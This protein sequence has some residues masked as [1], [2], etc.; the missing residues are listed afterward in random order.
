MRLAFVAPVYPYRGGI[1]QFAAHL[2]QEAA[3][4]HDVRVINF[5]RLYP[6]F[7]FPGKTQYDYSASPHSF[8]SDRII[9]SINPLSWLQAEQDL[10]RWSP[11]AVVFHYWHPF[12]APAYRAIA[13]G[14]SRDVR[15]IGI[16]HNVVSHDSGSLATRIARRFFRQLDGFVLHA[17][18]ERKSLSDL[19]GERRTAVAFHPIYNQFPGADKNKSK[20]R[21]ELGIQEDARVVLYFG[22][23]RPYKGVDLLLDAVKQ[24]ADVPNLLALVVGEIYSEREKITVAVREC[25][26]RA[27]LI[28]LYVPNEEVAPYFRAADLVVLPYRS[29]TQ[30]G[31]IPLA[32]AFDRPVIATR[33]GGLPDAVIEGESGYL[34]PPEDSSAVAEAMR[35]FFRLN[36]DL[37]PGIARMREQLGWSAYLDKLENLINQIPR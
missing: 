13:K 12:F 10:R 15:R 24:S 4:R 26:N 27:R 14:I 31:V 30:S 16:M 37:S 25:G 36:P 29:A 5:S 1:A 3:T 22:L 33:V 34:I 6:N 9:D 11:D 18:E 19:L 2:A 21:Q 32:Y 23:I 20:A 28:D 8:P 17:E 7:V 35:L